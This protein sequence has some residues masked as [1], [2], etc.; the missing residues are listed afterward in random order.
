VSLK[1]RI[2]LFGIV[3]LLIGVLVA[4]F[5]DYMSDLSSIES[6]IEFLA[7]VVSW[8]LLVLTDYDFRELIDNQNVPGPT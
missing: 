5:R 3:Y 8:P 2:G 1:G 7:V 6:F 4:S